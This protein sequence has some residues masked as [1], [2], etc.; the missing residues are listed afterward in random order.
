MATNSTFSIPFTSPYTLDEDIDFRTLY[1][2]KPLPYVEDR[3]VA[4]NAR[5]LIIGVQSKGQKER[6]VTFNVS[7]DILEVGC[8]CKSAEGTICAHGYHALHEL[9]W[10][11]KQFFTIFEPGKLVSIALE[12]KN[13]FHI[14]YS[15]PDEFIVPD[16]S[17]GHLYDFK[18]IETIGLEQLSALPTVAAPV[19]G[20]ELV[21][22]MVYAK[23]RWQNYL[24][25]LVPVIGT[26]D[27]AGENIKSFGKGFANINE[28]LLNTPGRQQLHDLSKSMYAAIPDKYTFEPEDLL[29]GKP[30][31]ADNFNQWEQ[32]LPMLAEQ[33]FVYKYKLAHP[34]Y[35][36][37]SAP[38]RKYLQQITISTERPQLQFVLKDKGNY[39]Q[40]S[41]QYLVRDVPIKSPLEDA[42][43]FVCT[44]TQYHLLASL[45]DAA[46][47]QWMSSFNNLISV[48]KPGF[49]AFEKEVLQRI[50]TIYPVLRK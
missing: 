12:N 24:P 1:P 10:K 30:H 21:W 19:R 36:I 28:N 41:L 32:E 44:A 2:G 15:N 18:K 9:C 14:N 27:K 34:K 3:V 40:L 46:M 37:K 4:Y 39:F 13:V 49:P 22:L 35:F 43:F 50:E 6:K 42:L 29:T 20:T 17:L 31:I 38:G 16:K 26:L 8:N 11:S 23:F 48:L 5:Q 7:P 25:A 47:A 33:Q 45:R